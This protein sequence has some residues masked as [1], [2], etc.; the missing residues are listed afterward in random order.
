MDLNDIALNNNHLITPN[1]A[2]QKFFIERIKHF[3]NEK[4]VLEMGPADGIMTEKLDPL[5]ECLTLLEGSSV[6]CNQLRNK[7]PNIKIINSL[8]EEYFPEEKYT[9]IIMGHVL[10][11]VKN[12][13]ELL[14]NVKGWLAP[15]GNIICAVPNS[16]SLHR[17]AAVLMGLLETEDSLNSSDMLHG[18]QRV[19]SPETFRNTFIKAGLK[20][21]HFGGFLIK[22][23]SNQQITDTWSPEMFR[24]FME[25]GERYP[26]I[27]AEIF[28]ISEN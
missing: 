24:A 19:F 5:C 20:I 8:F 26:D 23:A 28:I 4:N 18:H 13:V 22:T 9:S 7:F 11:H 12:P 2:S 21:N 17:Q 3:I 16:R 14:R 6:F 25:V 15:K 1:L 27:A 10:E